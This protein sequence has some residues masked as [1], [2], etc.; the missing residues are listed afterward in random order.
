MNT[1]F[2]L[3]FQAAAG[4]RMQKKALKKVRD[5]ESSHRHVIRKGH[6]APINRIDSP[7]TF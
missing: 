4:L 3:C 5:K 7:G 6:G 2:F 1:P